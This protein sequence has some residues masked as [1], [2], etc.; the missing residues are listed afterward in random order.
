MKAAFNLI[1]VFILAL[2]FTHQDCHAQWKKRVLVLHS[3]HQGLEWTDNITRGIQSVFS[4][5]QKQYEIHYEYL[6][7]KRNT[8]QAY[9]EQMV[10][11]ISA[12]NRHI[13]YEVVIVSDNTALKLVNEGS[14]H[15]SGH[16]QIVFCGINNY[17]K[18]LTNNLDNVTG[19]AEITN[20]RATIELMR[21]LHPERD[22]LI[23]VIDR[24]PTG[25]AIRTEFIDIEK[26]YKG[27]LKFVFFRDFSFE[28]IPDK[29]AGVDE[30]NL[31]YLTTFNRDRNNQFISYAEGI[32]MISRSTNVPIY[33]SWDFYLGKGITGGRITSG[34][35]QGQE[36]GKL[37]IKILT[38]HQANNLKVITS[39][40]NQFMF[41]YTYIKQHSINISS[42]PNGSQIINSPPSPYERY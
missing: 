9:T 7:T 12:Q 10:N 31:I 19:V 1:V 21:K 11:F 23:V 37:A 35:R 41:D 13:Q 28:E 15:F 16:P 38:G 22:Q 39:G 30:N 8:G 42:L 5:Y 36:A 3:Y 20:H 14:I 25:E 34:Y 17:H 18:N 40:P 2:G 29:L 4:P 32:E 27:K 33:G 26:S 6:D 24:T